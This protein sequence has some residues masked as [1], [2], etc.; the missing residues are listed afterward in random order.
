[1]ERG[2]SSIVPL[3]RSF[4]GDVR[5]DTAVMR[6]GLHKNL[7][8]SA[9]LAGPNR[10]S[11]ILVFL[12]YIRRIEITIESNLEFPKSEARNEDQYEKRGSVLLPAG[13]D[14]L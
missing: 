3:A 5:A 4:L 7:K 8:S 9:N 6:Y 10:Q 12:K 14:V 1:M 13:N 11:Q 2:E